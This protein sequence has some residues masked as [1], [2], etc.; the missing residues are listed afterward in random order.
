MR[1]ILKSLVALSLLTATVHAESVD[2]ELV[3]AADGSGSIDNEE[4]RCLS[5]TN[6]L[7]LP[8]FP[9]RDV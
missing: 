1:L 7:G 4:L 9:E 6:L 3:F 2:L 5:I 8:A